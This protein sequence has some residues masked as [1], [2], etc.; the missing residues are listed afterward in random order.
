M[1]DLLVGTISGTFLDIIGCGSRDSRYTYD[2]SL[3]LFLAVNRL[4]KTFVAFG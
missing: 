3:V 4:E 2:C 1:F